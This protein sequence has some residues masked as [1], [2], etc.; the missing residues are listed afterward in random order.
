MPSV[1][2]TIAID[3]PPTRVWSVLSDLQGY[4]RW[5]PLI[6]EVRGWL[7]EGAPLDLRVSLGPASARIGAR[8]SRV[9]PAEELRWRGPRSRLLG[10]VLC[11]EHYFLL[12]PHPSGCLLVHGETF[13][14]LTAKLVPPSAFARLEG[15]YQAMNE[16]LKR[17]AERG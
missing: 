3:A 14:G 13:T 16:A 6:T 15:A 9:R 17:T 4:G 12:E 1:H 10:H 7:E 5:N 8:V 2:T 11:G